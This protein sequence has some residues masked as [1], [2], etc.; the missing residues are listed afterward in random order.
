MAEFTEQEINP[1]YSTLSAKTRQNWRLLHHQQQARRDT[2]IRTK[3]GSRAIDAALA[4]EIRRL[5][6]HPIHP[7]RPVDA[8]RVLLELSGVVSAAQIGFC[9]PITAHSIMYLIKPLYQNW[10]NG[11]IPSH[12]GSTEK[13]DLRRLRSRNAN[14]LEPEFG[15]DVLRAEKRND[16]EV[17][18]D[19][20]VEPTLRPGAEIRAWRKILAHLV[21]GI[22]LEH[23][24]AVH[25]QTKCATVRH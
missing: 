6:G 21:R 12:E 1:R 20:R 8:R 13:Q 16:L 9:A 24:L 17:V 11:P 19:G 15:R 2:L 3:V 5:S 25:D 18:P 14:R 23:L 22:G 10:A 4:D 7:Q